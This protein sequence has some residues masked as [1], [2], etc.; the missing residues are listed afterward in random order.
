MRLL[1]GESPQAKTETLGVRITANRSR[2]DYGKL[3]TT[4]CL[5]VA[6]QT[7]LVVDSSLT[8]DGYRGHSSA[9]VT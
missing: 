5:A 7:G 1:P 4:P 9:R 8:D 2:G 3:A 6:A